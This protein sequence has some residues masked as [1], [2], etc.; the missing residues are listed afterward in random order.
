MAKYLHNI[1]IDEEKIS[2]RIADIKEA[3]NNLNEFRHSGTEDLKKGA[4]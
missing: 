2:E 4:R 1:P 3:L